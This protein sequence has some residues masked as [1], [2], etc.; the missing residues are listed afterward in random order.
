MH[1]S[2]PRLPEIPVI[3]TLRLRLRGHTVEDASNVSA[4]WGDSNVT[5]YVGGSPLTAEESWSRVLRYV[6]HWSLLGFG[7]WVVEEKI[8]G[9]FV[10]E[11]GFADYKRDLEPAMGTVP[12]LGWVLVPSKH[13][14]GFATEAVQG[15][16]DWGSA[17]FGHSPVACLI[18]PDNRASIHVAEKCGFRKRQPGMYK[19][20]PCLIFDR[21]LSAVDDR[22]FNGR[23]GCPLPEP[24]KGAS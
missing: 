4:L 20:N 13:G 19:G 23:D 3:E 16:L 6:G 21:M 7:Y 12:E 17:H 24:D 5:R 18:H 8:S 14:L 15:A 10:G 2:A 22:R 9:E 11:V 1:G